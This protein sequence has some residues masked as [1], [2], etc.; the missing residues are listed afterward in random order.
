MKGL[1][2]QVSRYSPCQWNQSQNFFTVSFWPLI[3]WNYNLT[4]FYTKIIIILPQ[5]YPLS[6]PQVSSKYPPVKLVK[7][8]TDTPFGVSDTYPEVSGKYRNWIRVRYELPPPNEV[9]VLPRIYPTNSKTLL[10]KARLIISST[11]LLKKHVL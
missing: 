6:I 8:S 4:P 11:A 1:Q 3:F 2:S 5:T 7:K 9:S 10:Y